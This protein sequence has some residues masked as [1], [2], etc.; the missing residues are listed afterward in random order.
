MLRRGSGVAAA[1]SATARFAHGSCV[2]RRTDT[3]QG[4]QPLARQGG[5]V[6]RGIESAGRQADRQLY[7][8]H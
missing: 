8:G 3:A 7:G 4:G 5:K 1:A 6:G 2:S